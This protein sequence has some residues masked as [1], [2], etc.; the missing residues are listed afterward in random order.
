MNIQEKKNKIQNC[1]N[2]QKK[3]L[4][5]LN[6]SNYFDTVSN[7][8]SLELQKEIIKAIPTTKPAN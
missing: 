4:D 3:L 7:I 6:F 8:R 5:K 1:F 2:E